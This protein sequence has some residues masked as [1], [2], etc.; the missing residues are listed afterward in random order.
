MSLGVA[1]VY[2]EMMPV[3]VDAKNQS[4]NSSVVSIY[5]NRCAISSK[6]IA[7]VW[8]WYDLD[9]CSNRASLNG[10]KSSKYEIETICT[11][12]HQT[13]AATGRRMRFL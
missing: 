7:F 12:L 4:R 9:V 1:I 8:E 10:S 11:S 3:G 13:K 2:L 5:R 6:A